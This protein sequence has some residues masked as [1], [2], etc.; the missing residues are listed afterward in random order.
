MSRK[1][2]RLIITLQ[3]VFM[4]LVLYAWYLLLVWRYQVG[5]ERS[6]GEVVRHRTQRAE[7][8]FGRPPRN[9]PANPSK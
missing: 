5:F 1:R 6:I 7:K 8:V 9:P 3:I 4:A 2:R